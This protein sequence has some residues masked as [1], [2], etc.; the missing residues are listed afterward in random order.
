MIDPEREEA[1]LRAYLGGAFDRRRLADYERQLEEEA[2]RIGDEQLLYRSSQAYLYNLTAFAMTR[3]KEPYLRVLR[4]LTRPP[5]SVLDYG[6][7]IGSDGL[8]LLEA[9]Y[10]VSFADFDNPSTHYL[11]WRL[12]QR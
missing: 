5:A 4:S 2:R 11:R 6:C 7:G 9:G 3:T 12:G 1:E 8:V 10:R